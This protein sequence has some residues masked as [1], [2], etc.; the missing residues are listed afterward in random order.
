MVSCL[1][2]RVKVVYLHHWLLIRSPSSLT[3]VLTFPVCFSVC[4]CISVCVL[5]LFF[6]LPCGCYD[7]KIVVGTTKGILENVKGSIHLNSKKKHLITFLYCFPD[8]QIV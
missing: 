5:V 8:M 4:V 3:P 2:G 6:S 1:G 7:Y